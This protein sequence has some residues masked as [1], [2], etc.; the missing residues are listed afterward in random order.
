MTFEEYWHSEYPPLYEVGKAVA[1]AAW[2][3]ANLEA[4]EA[5]TDLATARAELD[6]RRWIPVTERLP[7]NTD[8]ILTID[9]FRDVSTGW[10]SPIERI[11]FTH[12][13]FYGC[14]DARNGCVTHWQPLPT[15]TVSTPD[16]PANQYTP[17]VEL[18]VTEAQYYQRRYLEMSA[19]NARLTAY[20]GSLAIMP[21]EEWQTLSAEN[22]RLTA[23]C[24]AAAALLA[25]HDA[26]VPSER[27]EQ[28]FTA[29][30]EAEH[31]LETAY[32]QPRAARIQAAAPGTG[33]G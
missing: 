29:W 21:F 11:F 2:E 27:H 31:R 33:E 12:K 8:D 13:E 3:A 32:Q 15:F 25:F 5:R 23:E 28:G 26:G 18:G 10:Y 17:W 20:D 4:D 9:S 16:E 7:E 24:E 6:K 14:N 19:E 1:R 22:A 30:L